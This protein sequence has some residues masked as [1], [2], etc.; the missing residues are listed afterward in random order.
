MDKLKWWQKIAAAAFVVFSITAAVL[1]TVYHTEI[2]DAMLP[3]AR[4][5]K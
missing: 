1:V 4:K 2:L 3:V 5:M